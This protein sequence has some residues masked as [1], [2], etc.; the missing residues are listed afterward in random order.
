MQCMIS[1]VTFAIHR[2][3]LEWKDSLEIML[4]G[5]RAQH[6]YLDIDQGGEAVEILNM[7]YFILLKGLNETSRYLYLV[8]V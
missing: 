4:V 6:Q 1:Q 7:Q 8:R 5:E 3:S 2:A